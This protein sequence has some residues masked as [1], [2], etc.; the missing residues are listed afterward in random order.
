MSKLLCL[1]NVALI[2]CYISLRVNLLSWW[3][4]CSLRWKKLFTARNSSGLQSK[5]LMQKKPQ[6]HTQRQH[7]KQNKNPMKKQIQNHHH[8]QQK[9]PKRQEPSQ[10][11]HF[12]LAELGHNKLKILSQMYKKSS[13]TNSST[14]PHLPTLSFVDHLE[15]MG[16]F[17]NRRCYLNCPEQKH[18]VC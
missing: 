3:D 10:F 6:N 8:Q 15:N 1:Q 13:K 12:T 4:G 2:D 14:I 9:N 18:C 16:S 7:P 17:K 11:F 5:I